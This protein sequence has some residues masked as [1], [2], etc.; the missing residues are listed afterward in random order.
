MEGILKNIELSI[1]EILP[2]YL[3]FRLHL[4]VAAAGDK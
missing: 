2:V 3:A 4:S 1:F